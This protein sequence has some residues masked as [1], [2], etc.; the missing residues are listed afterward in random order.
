MSFIICS[1]DYDEENDLYSEINA[2]YSFTNILSN[3]GGL[4]IP[5]NAEVSV[6]SVKINKTE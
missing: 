3:G 5:K 4:I 1:N 2:P 6:Q